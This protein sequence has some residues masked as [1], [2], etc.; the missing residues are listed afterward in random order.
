[1]PQA[2]DVIAEAFAAH[3]V[4]IP[5]RRRQKLAF[6]TG[7]GETLYVVRKGLFLARVALPNAR[8]QVLS[9]F[10]PGDIVLARAMP[11]LAEAG[12]TA[13]SDRGEVWRLRSPVVKELADASPTLAHAISDRLADQAARLALHNAV[14]ASLTGP[15]R[16]AALM[17]ELALRIGTP[18][19]RGLVF[20]MPLSRTDIAEHLALNADTVSRIVSSMRTKKLIAVVGRGHLL[21]QDVEALAAEC[22]LAAALKHMH[23][24][25]PPFRGPESASAAPPPLRS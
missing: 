2:R 21:C 24:G 11:P 25:A 15:E 14:L 4:P 7:P 3:A 16:V 12:I 10:Y 9:L 5:T 8:H 13:A 1:M 19:P 20:D 23:G 17:T 18:S 6:D 22:P